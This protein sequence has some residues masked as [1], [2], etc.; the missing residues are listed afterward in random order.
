MD[1]RRYLLMGAVAACLAFNFILFVRTHG[2]FGIDLVWS[3]QFSR[4]LWQ[5]DPYPR[6]LEKS[7]GTGSPA[8]YYYA[9]LSFYVVA[10]FA[11]AGAY[12]SLIAGFVLLNAASGAAMW[13][14]LKDL[15]KDRALIGSLV[16][17][18]LPYH[19]IDF[20]RRG[21][22][23]EFAAFIFIP[24]LA[25][26]MEKRRIGLLAMAYAG[27]ILSHLPV[28]LLTSVFLIPVLIRRSWKQVAGLG[29]GAGLAAFYWLPAVLLMPMI[30]PALWARHFTPGF[31]H[32]YDAF[33]WPERRE[34]LLIA[35]AI[36]G[37]LWAAV[38]LRDKWRFW[39]LYAGAIA[40]V[41]A[42][43]VPGLWSIPLLVK[44][45]FPWRAMA[46]ADFAIATALARSAHDPKRLAIAMAPLLSLSIAVLVLPLPTGPSV[47]DLMTNY[48]DVAEY[49]FGITRDQM[50]V[51]AHWPAVVGAAISV[52]SLVMLAVAALGRQR[53]A[54]LARR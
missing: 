29:L 14:W 38:W 11:W 39:P 9:P 48:P 33:H 12:P 43:I 47:S 32:L 46:I 41:A 31:W 16:Y 25:R 40:I 13:H 44:V 28:A 53:F 8:F 3:D 23:A 49:Q 1:W 21:A 30:R 7:Y 15:G 45:Q 26:G 5:G 54:A 37:T 27:L 35:A 52:L 24:L 17:M 42:N 18:L 22:L 36:I 50:E 51:Y 6:W 2:S 34:T 19:L 10:L 20:G 4:Q